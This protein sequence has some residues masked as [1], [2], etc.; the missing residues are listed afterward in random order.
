M[1]HSSSKLRSN[2]KNFIILPMVFFVL[3]YL[4]IYI[5][6]WP[7]IKPLMSF[8]NMVFLNENYNHNKQIQVLTSRNSIVP[9]SGI[10]NLSDIQFPAYGDLF[11]HLKIDNVGVDADLYFGDGTSQLNSGLGLYNGSFIPGYGKTSLI[12]GHNN[13][14]FNGLKNIS[15]GDTVDISTNYGNYSYVVSDTKIFNNDYSNAYDLSADYENLILYTCYPFDTL[16]LTKSRLFV[17]CKYVSGP[18]IIL[19]K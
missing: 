17:Y 19:D 13:T 5:A 14:Y 8:G 15:I 11:A 4:I 18:D 9:D 12:A 2:R 6:A 10:I 7:I 16:G 3:G 1:R